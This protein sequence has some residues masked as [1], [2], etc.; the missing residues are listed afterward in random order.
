[1]RGRKMIPFSHVR[2]NKYIVRGL[3]VYRTGIVYGDDGEIKV[4]HNILNGKVEHICGDTLVREVSSKKL[5]RQIEEMVTTI[6]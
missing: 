5:R 2:E 1:V 4:A 3:M 6:L